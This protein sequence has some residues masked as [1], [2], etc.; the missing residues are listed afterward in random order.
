M[1]GATGSSTFAQWRWVRRGLGEAPGGGDGIQIASEIAW[2]SPG[3]DLPAGLDARIERGSGRPSSTPPASSPSTT[4][5]LH[6]LR[7]PWSAGRTACRSGGGSP[8]E[9]PDAWT[10]PPTERDGYF[11]E[12]WLGSRSNPYVV[13]RAIM[14]MEG[15]TLGKPWN[16]M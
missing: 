1:S 15:E 12:V 6:S 11:Y 2:S 9:A 7:P 14:A 13:A 4:W 8:S 3:E 10:A 16:S 5:S